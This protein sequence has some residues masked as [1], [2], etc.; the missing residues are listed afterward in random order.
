MQADTQK[1]SNS[2]VFI[3]IAFLA[4]FIIMPPLCRVFYKEEEVVEDTPAQEVALTNGT[5]TC[6]KTYAT[7]G[8]EVS[9]T[10]TYK[11][12]SIV[13]NVIVIKNPLLS[14]AGLTEEGQKEF[15][16]YAGMFSSLLTVPET[17]RVIDGTTITVTLDESLVDSVEDSSQISNQL[18]DALSL[19]NSYEV[20]GYSCST[21][22]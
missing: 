8:T 5:L 15:A 21:S 19:Q 3:V 9:S 6:T 11:D 7:M 17:N 1:Y 20:N 13:N 18:Q 4:I 2:T 16:E 14:E 22:E 10:A 12:G